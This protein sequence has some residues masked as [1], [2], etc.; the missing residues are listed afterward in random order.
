MTGWLWNAQF[1]NK[2]PALVRCHAASESKRESYQQ[3]GLY[4]QT[5]SVRQICT[6]HGKNF[7]SPMLIFHH[8]YYI[9]KS[10][11]PSTAPSL[12]RKDIIY[13][14]H[15]SPASSLSLAHSTT[16]Y[17]SVQTLCECYSNNL[18]YNWRGSQSCQLLLIAISLNNSVFFV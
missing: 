10:V 8:S 2:K 5:E 13:P 12:H 17:F 6:Q 1:I 14:P 7:R 15:S 11:I 3:Q 18:T 9:Q 16:D 4:E